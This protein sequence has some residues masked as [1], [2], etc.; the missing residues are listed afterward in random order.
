VCHRQNARDVFFWFTEIRKIQDRFLF[1]L[2]IISQVL[3]A[4]CAALE[5]RPD[6]LRSKYVYRRSH[7]ED[8]R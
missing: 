5:D 8:V 7:A 4:L 1:F 6:G 3:L 2:S